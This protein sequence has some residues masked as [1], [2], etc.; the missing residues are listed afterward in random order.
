MMQVCIIDPTKGI[1]EVPP[2]AVFAVTAAMEEGLTR[3]IDVE[4]H[5]GDE[6]ILT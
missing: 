2:M 6:S 4:E 3:R 1:E 5:R